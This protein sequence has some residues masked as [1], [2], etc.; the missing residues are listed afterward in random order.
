MGN[1]TEG[2]VTRDK[3]PRETGAPAMP[4]CLYGHSSPYPLS[5]W[6]PIPFI[7]E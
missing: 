5:P 6:C 2:K 3:T 7:N 4:G 1:G